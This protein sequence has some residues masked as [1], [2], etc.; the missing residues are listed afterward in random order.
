ME[1]TSI[2]LS[3]QHNPVKLLF[4]PT[5]IHS[6]LASGV[7]KT[8]AIKRTIFITVQRTNDLKTATSNDK[9]MLGNTTANAACGQQPAQTTVKADN[10][11]RGQ[12]AKRTTNNVDNSQN[13]QQSK[14]TTV[15]A[16]C[17]QQTTWPADNSQHGLRTTVN[18]AC[19]QQSTRPMDN[20][21]RG[22]Q[23][24]RPAD[25]TALCLHGA[26]K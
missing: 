3:V 21:K 7:Q 26:S 2:A 1:H 16:A 6:R 24:T 10:S 20:S 23:S 9:V 22:Q 5:L 11:Q 18:T 17:G 14:R 12:E 13:R 4:F 19:G 15:N 8:L 25:N